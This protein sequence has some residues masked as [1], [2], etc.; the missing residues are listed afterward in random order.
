M[1]KM[2]PELPTLYEY[3]TKGGI[4]AGLETLPDTFQLN[5]KNITIFSGTIHYFRVH[6]DYWRDRLRKL[7]AAG[8]NAVET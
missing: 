2:D 3:Y 6:P 4:I 5:K 7:R 8:F 1:S